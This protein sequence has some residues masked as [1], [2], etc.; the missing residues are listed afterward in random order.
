MTLLLGLTLLLANSGR[1]NA[2]EDSED[3]E[4]SDAAPAANAAPKDLDD[5][6]AEPDP[7]AE[8]D[9]AER[10]K[11]KAKKKAKAKPKAAKADEDDD[12]PAGVAPEGS[13]TSVDPAATGQTPAR[14][15][16]TAELVAGTPIDSSNRDLYGIGGGGGVGAEIYIMPLL[17][18]HLEGYFLR[19]SKDQ[20]AG[21]TNLIAGGVGPRLHFG[22]ALFGQQTRHDAWVDAHLNYG[23]SGGIGRPGFDA[24]AAVQWEVAPDVRVGPV[25]RYQFGSDPLDKNAQLITAGV[26]LTY[27]GRAH[28]TVTPPAPVVEL[29]F[30]NDGVL[31]GEDECRKKPAGER[32]DPERPGCPL[33]DVDDDGVP[34]I[35]DECVTEPAGDNPNPKRPGCPAAKVVA[36]DKIAKVKGGKIEIFQQVYFETNSATIEERSNEVL[37]VVAKLI[38]GLDG[39]R[40]RVEGHTDDVGTDAY[41]LDLSKRRA[42]AVAQWLVQYGDVDAAQLETEGYGKTRPLVQGAADREPNRRVEFVI[43]DE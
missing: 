33:S 14:V 37:Q 15:N 6:A 32:P 18:I 9:P 20:A 23:S 40:V 19:F 22:T 42:R 11:P 5:D 2:A 28:G 41:N 24:A 27:G 31:D 38:R 35:E 3:S 16:F 43:I 8:A 30:D 25:L 13:S 12:A 26:T 7:E 4:A 36:E 39:K 10:P 1:S 21:S 29:D 34:D 17:G